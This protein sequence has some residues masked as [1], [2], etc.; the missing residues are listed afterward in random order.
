MCILADNLHSTVSNQQ[1]LKSQITDDATL[2]VMFTCERDSMS[3]QYT[4]WL[5]LYIPCGLTIS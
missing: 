5:F 1:T 4:P 2:L 3:G